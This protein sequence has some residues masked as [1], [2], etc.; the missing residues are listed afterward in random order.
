MTG[1]TQP[2]PPPLTGTIAGRCAVL[3]GP[4]DAGG[5][6][7][8]GQ[9]APQQPALQRDSAHVREVLMTGGEAATLMCGLPA[10]LDEVDH[11]DPGQRILCLRQTTMFGRDR[12]AVYRAIHEAGHAMQH[13]ANGPLWRIRQNLWTFRLLS[14]CLV[15]LGLALLGT[16]SPVPGVLAFL[17]ACGAS[18]MR[19]AIVVTSEA[20][21]SRY[22]L[23]WLSRSFVLGPDKLHEARAYLRSLRD[24]YWQMLW[25]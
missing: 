20:Q 24:T 18:V 16:G 19:A 21:A 9:V 22:A 23:R 15:A 13:E 7:G 11:Y 3:A 17:A 6:R 4:G 14:I 5:E 1:E 8:V 10:V 12:F 2:S 25:R